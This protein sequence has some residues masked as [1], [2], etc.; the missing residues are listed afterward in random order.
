MPAIEEENVMSVARCHSMPVSIIHTRWWLGRGE[1][2]PSPLQQSKWIAPSKKWGFTLP[3]L[4]ETKSRNS[5]QMKS[6]NLPSNGPEYAT[7]PDLKDTIYYIVS[8]LEEAERANSSESWRWSGDTSRYK[9]VKQLKGLGRTEAL[10]HRMPVVQS[11]TVSW[12]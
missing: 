7:I 2:L 6:R 9:A 10:L 11:A 12:S 3:L 4:A 8:K 1:K 5:W